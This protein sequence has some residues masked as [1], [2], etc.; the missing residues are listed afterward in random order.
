VEQLLKKNNNI[1]LVQIVSALLIVNYHTSALDIPV[2]KHIAKFGFIF[3]TVF[4]FLSG[5]LLSKSLS[6]KPAPGFR[7]FISRRINRIYPSLHV[8]LLAIAI[9]YLFTGHEFSLRSL[10]LAATGFSYYFN[11]NTFGLHLWF[12]SVVLVCYILSIPTHHALKRC[13]LAFFLVLSGLF[14]GTVLAREGSLNGLYNKVSSDILYR[15]IYHYIVFSIAIYMGTINNGDIPPGKK[16]IGLLLIAFPLYV[17]LQHDKYMGGITIGLSIFLAICIIQVIL[18]IS[19]FVDKHLS[20]ILL[21]SPLT[22][23]LY[24]VHYSIIGAV[25]GSCHGKFISYPLIFIFSIAVAFMVLMLSKPYEQLTRRWTGL[26]LHRT[27]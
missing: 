27:S 22:Y 25:N 8:A 13:P 19:P 3:N 6:A 26:L 14:L 10:L 7:Q 18:I 16:W 9:I 20:L 24:L 17:W 15:F 12:V 21:L 2:L 1:A 11:D 4:V 5:Y 23:E